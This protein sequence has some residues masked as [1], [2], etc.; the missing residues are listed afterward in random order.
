MK[1]IATK[2]YNV[3]ING[4]ISA[5]NL[6]EDNTILWEPKTKPIF[7][8][9][10][11]LKPDCIILHQEHL[12]KHVVEALEYYKPLS[13]IIGIYKPEISNS[14]LCYPSNIPPAIKKNI[15]NG[16]EIRLAANIAQLKGGF[17]ID[18]MKSDVV[19]IYNQ[20]LSKQCINLLNIL[21]GKFA[22]ENLSI[23]VIGGLSPSIFNLGH[24]TIQEN[25]CF[26]QSTKVC[27][28]IDEH[29]LYDCAANKCF[30]LSTSEQ[31]IF[32]NNLDELEKF[33]QEE[34]LRRSIIKKAY[35]KVMGE[36]TYFHRV[37]ALGK[38]LDI[39]KWTNKSLEVLSK[40]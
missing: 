30:A 31:D 12:N 2:H 8:M 3:I 20:P 9:F 11:E 29:I 26:M 25:L 34:K 16:F 38:H 33:V 27:L 10:E 4:L 19:L 13:I 21:D 40:I 37:A 18:N 32:P 7:D 35:K 5:L 15:Q 28:D 39:S 6:I 1:I 17:Y 36:H 14:I 24:T 23:K 22:Y